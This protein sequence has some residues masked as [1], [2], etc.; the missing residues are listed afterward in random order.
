MG[1]FQICISPLVSEKWKNIQEKFIQRISEDIA[2]AQRNGL[3]RKDVHNELVARGW[4]FT[5]EMYLWEIVRNEYEPLSNK[6]LRISRLFILKDSIYN[7]GAQ[8]ASI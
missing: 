4:F 7:F 5:N 8:I 3:A 6:L 2:Y 1:I